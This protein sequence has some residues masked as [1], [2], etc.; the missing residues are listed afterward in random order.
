[1][2]IAFE[3]QVLEEIPGEPDDVQMDMVITEQTEYRR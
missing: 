1:M 3:M 2:G